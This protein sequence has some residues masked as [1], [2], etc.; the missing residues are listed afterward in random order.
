VI[1]DHD[2]ISRLIDVYPILFSI[3]GNLNAKEILQFSE[4]L[5]LKF[6]CRILLDRVDDFNCL[7]E[8]NEV[9]HPACNTDSSCRVEVDAVIS[10]ISHKPNRLQISLKLVV[11]IPC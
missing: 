11:P 10:M 1:Q 8:N 7:D 4:I 5:E 2:D 3:L 6:T 9:I